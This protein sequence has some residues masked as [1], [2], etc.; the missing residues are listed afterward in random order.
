MSTRGSS[1]RLFVG[2]YP[3][4]RISDVLGTLSSDVDLGP[5][6]LTPPGQVH[7]TACFIGERS[8]RDL[9]DVEESVERSVSGLASFSIQ[10]LAMRTLPRR[11]RARTLVV[12][13]DRPTPLLDIHERLIRRLARHPHPD[14]RNRF[15]PH[16]TIARFHPPG[17]SAALEQPVDTP[18]FPIEDVRLMRSVLHPD[19]ARHDVIRTFPLDG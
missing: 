3:D 9:P 6:R 13:T 15:L 2:L 14:A 18:P 16:L 11:G 19:G 4:P 12:E 8:A 10:P 17:A 7:L 1:L 5:L